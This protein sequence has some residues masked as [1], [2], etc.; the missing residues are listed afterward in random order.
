MVTGNPALIGRREHLIQRI[1]G[2]LDELALLTASPRH[3]FMALQKHQVPE[4]AGLYILY[5]EQPFVVLYVGKALRRGKPSTQ[6]DG[7][8]FR[9]MENH[10]GKRGDDNFVRYVQEQFEFST[11]EQA[12]F[13]I[14]NH[15]SVHWR[16]VADVRK[17]CFLE[18]CAIAVM[19]PSLNRG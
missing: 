19:Q 6:C 16:E 3:C 2:L 4:T 9:I 17:L 5:Q 14:V 7:L 11:R 8:R 1:E 13:H 12:R 18:H 10:L 15:C